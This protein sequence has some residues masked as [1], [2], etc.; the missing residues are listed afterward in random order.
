MKVNLS[1]LGKVNKPQINVVILCAGK[2]TR[3]E[4][5]KEFPEQP[6]SLIKINGKPILLYI[7]KTLK[8]TI[9]FK[10]LTIVC[11][12]DTEHM[13]LKYTHDMNP[14]FVVQPEPL[15]TAHA[16][17][18]AIQDMSEPVMIVNGDCVNFI[19]RLAKFCMIN[20]FIT[21]Y[22]KTSIHGEFAVVKGLLP[23]LSINRLSAILPEFGTPTPLTPSGCYFFTQP[24]LVKSIILSQK[25]RPNNELHLSDT[26]NTMLE[27]NVR[28]LTVTSTLFFDLGNYDVF[29]L[30]KFKLLAF[31][32]G[33][34]I[35]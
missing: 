35:P 3:M 25:P 14:K 19:P 10:S 31:L 17:L 11:P 21:I 32:D 15:G 1:L 12:P 5:Y 2:G 26:I 7:I 13:F 27:N 28:I 29:E 6:K 34:N 23:K 16:S 4:P 33:G 20:N 8:F 22:Y 9:Q 30:N 24:E 18:L